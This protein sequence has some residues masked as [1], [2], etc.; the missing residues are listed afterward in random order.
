M[1]FEDRGVW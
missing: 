1:P